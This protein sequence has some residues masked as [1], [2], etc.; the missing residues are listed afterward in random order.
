MVVLDGEFN[1]YRNKILP[2]A[3]EDPLVGAAVSVVAMYH[4]TPLQRHLQNPA[5]LGFQNIIR[6]L[7]QRSKQTGG[8][9]ISAWTAVI[10][11]LTGETVIGGTNLPYLF[12]MLEHLARANTPSDSDMYTFLSEQTRMMTLFARPLLGEDSGTETLAF[13]PEAYFDFISNAAMLYPQEAP[14][15]SLVQRFIRLACNLYLTR[16][17][18]NPP[19]ASTVEALEALRRLSLR[20]QPSQPS[21]HTLVWAFF[22]AAAESSTGSHREFFTHRLREVFKRT[23]FRNIPT[24]IS[25][26]ETLWSVQ[27]TARRWTEV[28]PEVMPV[29]II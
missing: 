10:V 2:L 20:I 21:H 15:I 5:D 18:S 17:M 25:A 3:C 29:F 12:K 19:H 14:H 13:R 9:D 23:G 11:L 7:H 27:D 1:G 28:L 4:L 24:A 22:I 8:L 26:L 16:A 6:H